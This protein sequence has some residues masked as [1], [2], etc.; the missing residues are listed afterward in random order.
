MTS[1]RTHG[2]QRRLPFG[3]E[4]THEGAHF[5]VWAPRRQRVSALVEGREVPLEP[6]LDG[7]FSGFDAEGRAGRHYVLRLDDGV[8]I[9]DPASR[10]QPFGPSGPSELVDSAAFDWTDANWQGR[11]L[12]G[13]ILYELHIGTFTTEGTWEA[14]AERLPELVELGVTSI[15]VMPVADFPGLFG[16][17]YDGVALFAP[18]HG[19]GRPDDMRRFVDGAHS[20]GLGVILDIVCNHLGPAGSTL[21]EL[22]DD[23]FSRSHVTD[24]GPGINFDGR[25]SQAVRAFFLALARFWIEEYHVDG[26]RLDAT[27]SIEDGS[28]EHILSAFV[29][30]ARA[31]AAPRSVVLVAENERQDARLARSRETG[32]FGFD[33]IWNDDFH[34]AALVALTG[35]KEAYYTDYLGSAQE[36][37][38]AAKR[39]FLYQGQRYAWHRARRGSSAVELPASA[40]VVYL[41][42]HDQVANSERGERLNRLAAPGA[43][44]AMVALCLLMPGVPMLF[45]GQEFD[46][47]RP[48]VFFADHEPALAAEVDRGRKEFLRQ[49]RS[50]ATQPIQDALALPSDPHS[51][52]G[53][54]LDDV[55]R[56]SAGATFALHR[57]LIRIRRHDPVLRDPNPKVD[58]AVLAPHAFVLRWFGDEERLLV[59]NLGRD[60]HLVPAPEPLLAP[61]EGRRWQ[62]RWSS[63]D[64]RYGGRGT[65]PVE[66][67]EDGWRLPGRCAVFLASVTH[68]VVK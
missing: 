27:H 61:P 68:E 41:E 50:F 31:A 13:Q 20:C 65:A 47:S 5:R 18:Y 45:Q 46:S 44:R 32:G 2:K 55:E 7:W 60:I 9:S 63:E 39:G 24:W 42:N 67:E 3:A 10:F 64:A 37:V 19:Y 34:H 49:F 23:F 52:H 51:F 58:G 40:F 21:P 33:A 43:Y 26:Y 66:T 1:W 48:F 30:A 29:R 54:K 22:T 8:E 57:D 16:W 36:L 17:G 15:E 28:E 56:R 38:S 6:E 59:V 12:E 62:A 35:R 14:A 11:V 25:G 4:V 53:C